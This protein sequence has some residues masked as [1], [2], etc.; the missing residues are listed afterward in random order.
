MAIGG[1]AA[2]TKRFKV[3]RES[4]ESPGPVIPPCEGAWQGAYLDDS[5]R[6]QIAWFVTLDDVPAN[7]EG[8][9]VRLLKATEEGVAGHLMILDG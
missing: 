6:A 9:P 8:H 5:L 1:S 7:I 3:E 4:T 2:V